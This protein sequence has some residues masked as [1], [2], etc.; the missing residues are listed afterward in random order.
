MAR[1]FSPWLRMVGVV[2]LFIAGTQDLQAQTTDSLA[3]EGAA[4]NSGSWFEASLD[5]VKK[6][7]VPIWTLPLTVFGSIA[8][9]FFVLRHSSRKRE[10]KSNDF[11]A[12][13]DKNPI[14]SL[15][16]DHRLRIQ[17][18]NGAAGHAFKRSPR[19]L[20]GHYLPNLLTLVDGAEWP[21][22][23][24]ETV[25]LHAYFTEGDDASI[26]VL[27]TP[28]IGRKQK[29]VLIQLRNLSE[30]D[31][32]VQKFKSFQKALLTHAPLE[33]AVLT[34]EGRYIYSNAQE[35]HK[36]LF[37]ASIVGKTD[38]EWCSE[39]GLHPEIAVRRR[40][41]RRKAVVEKRPVA[42]EEQLD[43]GT[44]K[45]QTIRRQYYPILEDDE[46][47]SVV[48]SYG[49]DITTQKTMQHV[50][51]EA[52]AEA[53]KM[54]RIKD[55]FLQNISHEFRTP[56]TGIMGFAEILKEEVSDDLREFAELVEQSGRRLM[57]TLNAMLEL[58]G[59]EAETM[60]F[61]PQV[62][63]I[64]EEV[65]KTINQLHQEAAKKGLFLRI[66]S[67]SADAFVYVD[68]ASLQR[69]LYNVIE[70]A[71][72]FTQTGGIV[73]DIILD[74]AFVE[75][76]VMD[77]GVGMGEAFLPTMFDSFNQ[78][79]YGDARA[80]EGMGLGLAISKQLV[81]QMGGTIQ[82]MSR[83][84]EG[85]AFNIILPSAFPA[86]SEEGYERPQLMLIDKSPEAYKLMRY[87][88][89]SA[90]DVDAVRTVNDAVLRLQEQSYDAIL[91][92]LELEGPGTSK[93]IIDSLRESLGTSKIPI[94]ATDASLLPVSAEHYHTLGF[95]HVIPKPFKR[96]DLLKVLAE[97]LT[98]ES[99]VPIQAEG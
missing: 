43:E 18:T 63:D 79:S 72:K 2:L 32:H 69:I 78:E 27:F 76:K 6:A 35:Q 41:Y 88:V 30:R 46:S 95:D 96:K 29:G 68:Q 9:M 42:F 99:S 58:A 71:I 74:P 52:Q 57:N 17:R 1:T 4:P 36:L 45:T 86:N 51:A 98:R 26:E 8:L 80:F 34:P 97:V 31:Q 91:L 84:E 87:H 5:Q 50:V 53:E 89:A 61:V 37:G 55:V 16:C 66:A 90:I 54:E 38:V 59:L 24:E 15:V 10:R 73:V 65:E 75:I 64:Q 62:M 67:T 20:R 12:L 48:V 77:T 13:F 47:V 28:C 82:V 7:S 70:N 81:E 33:V 25:Q 14:P 60:Q 3:V 94:I 22:G 21:E 92:A 40:T 11:F 56:L 39:T 19:H 44:E 85:S 23:G 93:P 83:K 49:H